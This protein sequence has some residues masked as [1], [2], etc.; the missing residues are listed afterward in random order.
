[1]R[2]DIIWP[3]AKNKGHVKGQHSQS[4]EAAAGEERDRC[5]V[6]DMDDRVDVRA[7]PQNFPIQIM[8]NAGDPRAK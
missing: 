3:L 2:V 6:M 4:C 1:M 7:Q 5:I 8:S